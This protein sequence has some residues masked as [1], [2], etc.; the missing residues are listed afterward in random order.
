MS[1]RQFKQEVGMTPGDYVESMRLEAGRRLAEET[2]TP[3]KKIARDLGFNDDVAF[4][5]AFVRK[6][7]VSP[8]VYRR[9]F[10]A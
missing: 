7:G 10:G 6:F 2:N 1:A 3:M 5:R 8:V 9:S 4:R